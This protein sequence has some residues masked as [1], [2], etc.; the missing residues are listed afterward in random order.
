MSALSVL[1]SRANAAAKRV[2]M[3]F[4]KQESELKCIQLQK[5]I[6]IAKAEEQALS[7]VL[8]KTID[9]TNEQHK[10]EALDYKKDIKPK[11]E[12]VSDDKKDIKPKPEDLEKQLEI[13]LPLNPKASS[14]D[15]SDVNATL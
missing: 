9:K 5:E 2:E 3:S 6:A 15:N 14:F 10:K 1:L 8:D 12:A 4:L 13:K 11:L 7:D